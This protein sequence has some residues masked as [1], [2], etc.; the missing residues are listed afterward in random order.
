MSRRGIGP[1]RMLAGY[2]AFVITH[3]TLIP[4]DETLNGL[5]V[6]SFGFGH[7]G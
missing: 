2:L 1:K 4:G 7:V 3:A 5:R 6:V